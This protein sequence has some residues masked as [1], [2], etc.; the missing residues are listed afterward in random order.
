MS[1]QSVLNNVEIKI[2]DLEDSV[3]GSRNHH[4]VPGTPGYR[5]PEVYG[6]ELVLSMC[7][8]LLLKDSLESGWAYSVDVFAIGCMAYEMWT[9]VPLVP[10]TED[11]REYLFFIEKAIGMFSQLQAHDICEL[12][13]DMFRMKTRVPR[14]KAHGMRLKSLLKLKHYIV[15]TKWLKVRDPVCLFLGASTDI[16]LRDLL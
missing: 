13:S 16:V 1:L 15:E 7:L 10:W 9:G 2:I 14:V 4:F 8:V 3:S 12:Y 6:S 11:V 5:P